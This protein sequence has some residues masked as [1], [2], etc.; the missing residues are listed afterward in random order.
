MPFVIMLHHNPSKG[1]LY[2]QAIIWGC[3]LLALVISEV[4]DFIRH[5]R[6]F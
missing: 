2:L 4:R 5:R 3:F 6:K 1:F